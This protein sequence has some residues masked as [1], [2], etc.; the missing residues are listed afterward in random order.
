M[1]AFCDRLGSDG[2]YAFEELGFSTSS[3][4]ELLQKPN[5]QATDLTMRASQCEVVRVLGKLVTLHFRSPDHGW[6]QTQMSRELGARLKALVDSGQLTTSS[7]DEDLKTL[8]D[9]FLLDVI[10]RGDVPF[11]E[12]TVRVRMEANG[13]TWWPSDDTMHILQN[14]LG[15]RDAR[16]VPR[17]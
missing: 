8:L 2:A 15:L 4:D 1:Q 6:V 11:N 16:T 5:G 10:R 12:M 3:I 9:K 7:T 14:G 17:D 13:D